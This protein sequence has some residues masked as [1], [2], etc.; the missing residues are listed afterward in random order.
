MTLGNLQRLIQK[1]LMNCA[2]QTEVITDVTPKVGMQ[3]HS[4]TFAHSSA[5]VD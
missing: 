5:V 2:L 3:D 4:K 1:E